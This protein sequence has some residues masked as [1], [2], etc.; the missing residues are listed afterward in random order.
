[1]NELKNYTYGEMCDEIIKDHEIAFYCD[2][3]N[4]VL[5]WVETVMDDNF[6]MLYKKE[7]TK[8]ID[9]YNAEFIKSNKKECLE[10]I[11]L[12]KKSDS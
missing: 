10:R 4:S 5:F 12:Y 9:V 1:M 6:V 7:Y 11:E 8:F 2:E 3:I